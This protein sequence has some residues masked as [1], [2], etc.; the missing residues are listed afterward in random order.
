MRVNLSTLPFFDFSRRE[1]LKGAAATAG[2]FCWA[3]TSI[4]TRGLRPGARPRPKART[5]P[6][7][8]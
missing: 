8:F 7:F 3:P 4:L 6:I 2:A 5:I 1:F